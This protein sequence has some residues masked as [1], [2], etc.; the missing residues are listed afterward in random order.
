[1]SRVEDTQVDI[2]AL[3]LELV[4]EFSKLQDYIDHAVGMYAAKRAPA[5]WAFL[6]ESNVLDRIGDQQRPRLVIAIADDLGTG[7][8]LSKFRDVYYCVK[9]IRDFV[10]HGTYT[11]RVDAD[12]LVIHANYVTGPN[13]KLRGIKKRES[14][15]ITRG[16]LNA[17]LNE[18]R[19]LLQHVQFLVA[20][21]DLTTAVMFRGQEMTFSRPPADPSDWD[22]KKFTSQL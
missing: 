5:L 20:T 15:N 9:D 7:A 3:A 16:Q 13:I 18:A 22:G 8:D 14:L 11:Q 10:A 21:S 1:M 17:R 6:E 12:N 4:G 19:W 2:A